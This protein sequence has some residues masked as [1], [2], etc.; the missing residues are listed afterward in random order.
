MRWAGL[1]ILRCSVGVVFLVLDP[2]HSFDHDEMEKKN[3]EQPLPF[4]FIFSCAR[5]R[6]HTAPPP[7]LCAST[8][9]DGPV[10]QWVFLLLFF[11]RVAFPA[12]TPV[13][14]VA[15]TT[16]ATIRQM[17]VNGS[18]VFTNRP[19]LAHAPTSDTHTPHEHT[20]TVVRAF[21][22]IPWKTANGQSEPV[23]HVT[24]VPLEPQVHLH[25]VPR[26]QVGQA[27]AIETARHERVTVVAEEIV[28]RPHTQLYTHATTWS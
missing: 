13:S 3:H 17:I 28:L 12:Q 27:H 16:A 1:V 4:P 15:S 24:A 19:K 18:H 6:T 22:L 25:H 2:T 10:T 26:A 21:S 14:L 5:S 9:T 7:S 11:F 23:P 20:V 8:D